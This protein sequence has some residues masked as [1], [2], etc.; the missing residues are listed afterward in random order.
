MEALQGSAERRD[1]LD[2]WMEDR[3][4]ELRVRWSEVARRA[5]MSPQN[6]LRIRKGQISISWDAADGIED[7]LLWDRGSV[8]AAVLNGTKPT[9]R[10]NDESARVES[11]PAAASVGWTVEM[12][13]FYQILKA[14]FH[15]EGLEMNE[16]NVLSAID[17]LRI[18]LP[19]RVARQDRIPN[20]SR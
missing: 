9:P 3:R 12:E 5:G 6:L 13:A 11:L 1:Q 15:A 2:A 7:A 17:Q 20:D 19:R 18:E 4:R 16:A 14:K 8:E 10:G